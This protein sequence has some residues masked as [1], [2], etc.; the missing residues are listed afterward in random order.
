MVN[1]RPVHP[2]SHGALRL[3]LELD[4]ETVTEVRPAIGHLHI[5]VEKNIVHHTWAQGA[6]FCARMDCLA[7]LRN[8]TTFCLG[9]ER[10]L[11]IEDQIPRR[12]A[13]SGCHDGAR[14]DLA[15][16]LHRHQGME[17]GGPVARGDVPCLSS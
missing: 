9:V 10:L 1:L 11:D 12:P 16:G 6:T 17:I 2:A 8:E 5:G 3:V 15:P 13:S 4:G 7:P 14:P